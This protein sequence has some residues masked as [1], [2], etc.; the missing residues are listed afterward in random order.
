[1]LCSNKSTKDKAFKLK[2]ETYADEIIMVN[3]LE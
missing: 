2:D 1:M 3:F